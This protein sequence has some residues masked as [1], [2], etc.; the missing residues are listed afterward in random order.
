MNA[1][2]DVVNGCSAF[3][4]EDFLLAGLY[5]VSA[6]LGGSL[7]LAGFWMSAV[8]FWHLFVAA[9]VLGIII[10]ILK[11]PPLKKWMERC[12]FSASISQS[13]IYASVDEELQAYN[14]IVG[15]F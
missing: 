9:I 14:S 10:G 2:I 6:L 15:A 4:E 3:S 7:S 12:F 8:I 1:S 5:G 11:K 13:K